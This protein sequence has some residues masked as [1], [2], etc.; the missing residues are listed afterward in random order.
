VEPNAVRTIDPWDM[1]NLRSRGFSV[2][3]QL[4]A[5]A[6]GLLVLLAVVGVVGL[7]RLSSVNHKA[8]AMYTNSV[9]SLQSMSRFGVALDDQQRLLLRGVVYLR[10]ADK[11]AEVDTQLAAAVKTA[12]AALAAQMSGFLLPAEKPLMASI[13]KQYAA[14]KAIRESVRAA[15]KTGDRAAT[16]KQVDVAVPAYKALA[17]P[18]AQDLQVNSSAANDFRGQIDDAYHSG[19]TLIIALIVVAIL[20]GV[21]VALFVARR[22]VGGVR[23]VLR[24][25]EGISEGDLDQTV[26]VRSRDEIGAMATAFGRMIEYLRGLSSSAER[27][28][29]GDLTVDVAPKS[30]RDALGTSFAKM[31]TSLR[32]TVGQVQATASSV[33]ASSQQMAS[34]SEEAGRAVGEIANAVAEVASGAERQV[35]MVEAQR[36][37][38]G[39]TARA[40][41]A[42]RQVAEDGASAAEHATGAMQAMQE[43]S[44]EVSTAIRSL[45]VKSD[46]IGGIVKTISGIAR[47]TNLLALNAAIEAARA[48]EQ[49]RGFA[50]VAE[51]VRKLAEESQ[52]AAG[53]ISGLVGEIQDETA[54][55][56]TIVQHGA[57]RSREGAEVVEQ[58]RAAFEEIVRSVH[59]VSVRIDEISTATNEVAAVAEQSSASSEQ[60]SASTQQTSASAQ[61]IAASAQEL[62]RTAEELER[63]VSRFELAKA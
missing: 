49:G 36:V 9:M 33:S 31:T 5:L 21:A 20:L 41:D 18:A 63:L 62:A 15:T 3:A 32:D 46:A 45:A 61:E 23:Q 42:A 60:V 47:Q 7:T 12:D 57:D 19:R 35:R 6:G 50:V 8:D 55:T 40:A 16:L 22:L 30:P 38:A 4:F 10:Q 53:S 54:H 25:A 14:Y 51:E 39:D 26:D 11:Q 44:D 13:T 37:S 59:E 2:L 17:A 28:A 27:V 48:G 58:A 29:A 52:R 24:A 1:N 56:V 43:S 34:T